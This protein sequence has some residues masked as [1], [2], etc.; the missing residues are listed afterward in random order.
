MFELNKTLL[1]V[2]SIILLGKVQNILPETARQ[3]KQVSCSAMLGMFSII[4]MSS[5]LLQE[6]PDL[7]EGDEAEMLPAT[8]TPMGETLL[9]R[10]YLLDEANSSTQLL[11][12]PPGNDLLTST[13]SQQKSSK[14]NTH[15]PLQPVADIPM[16]SLP[17]S[18]PVTPQTFSRP[19]TASKALQQHC[20]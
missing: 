11:S 6:D 20:K 4:I 9:I 10:E 18:R 1:M 15:Q 3:F 13:A 5:D 12:S 14:G 2:G 7:I 19:H 8:D 17:Y 16:Q